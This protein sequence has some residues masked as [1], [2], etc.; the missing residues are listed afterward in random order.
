MNLDH[1]VGREAEARLILANVTANRSTLVIGEAGVGKSALLEVLQPVLEEEGKLIHCTRL[2]PFGPF[3]KECFTG[4]HDLRLI[5]EQTSS[6]SD[7]LKLW[8]KQHATNEEK[9]R[10]LLEL[11]RQHRDIIVV[12]DDAS[13]VTQSSRPWLEQM[14]ETITVLAA[15]DPFSAQEKQL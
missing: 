8:G 3:I 13:G 10:A 1:F 7:D 15:T 12:I 11:M 2:S 4:L 5:P 14:L 9:A 6:V